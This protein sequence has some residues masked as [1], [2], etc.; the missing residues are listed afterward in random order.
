MSIQLHISILSRTA[1]FSAFC[2]AEFTSFYQLVP[3]GLQ[4]YI[5]SIIAY[6]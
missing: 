5:D 1:G 6:T 4:A 3:M 2:E